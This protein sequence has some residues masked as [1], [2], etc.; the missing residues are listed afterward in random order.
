MTFLEAAIQILKQERQPLHYKRLA[1]IAVE[2]NLLTVVGRTPEL[3]MQQRLNDAL[4]KNDPELP[5]TREKPGVYGLRSY[6]S[7]EKASEVTAGPATVPA[8]PAAILP[9]AAQEKV[10]SPAPRLTTPSEISTTMTGEEK[11]RRRRRGGRGRR[12]SSDLDAAAIARKN[13]G[14]A[15]AP[16]IPSAPAPEPAAP[17]ERPT[18]PRDLPTVRQEPR[19]AAPAA[20]N[21]GAAVKETLPEEAQPVKEMAFIDALVDVLRQ[22]EGRILHVRQLVD[23]AL[24]RRLVKGSAPELWRVARTA[25][26]ADTR[27]REAAGQ[28]PRVR[29]LGNAHYVLAERKLEPELAQ[30]ERTVAQDARKLRD[31]TRATL[32]RRLARLSLPLLEGFTRLLLE[33]M[34][35]VDLEP[36]KQGEGVAYWGG[37]WPQA[38]R[39]VKVLI[40]IRSGEADIGRRAVAEL[41]EGLRARAFDQGLLLAL[42]QAG[43][44]ARAELAQAGGVIEL[45]DGEAF[46]STCAALGFGIVCRNLPVEALDHELLVELTET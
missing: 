46:V 24:K 25:L 7:V 2:R 4:K 20:Q 1:Q 5:L 29:L 36:V 32:R 34:G 35:L 15:I 21:E 3:T 11:R 17:T 10:E 45:R 44:E 9:T 41:R 22:G 40:A 12:A 30:H 19:P 28:R 16:P 33:R 14:Q 18:P 13:A 37:L 38:G 43:A 42:G 27:T 6:P 26:L 23:M 31:A 39:R 8:P